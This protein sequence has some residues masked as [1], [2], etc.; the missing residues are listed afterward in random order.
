PNWRVFAF[1]RGAPG[2]ADFQNLDATEMEQGHPVGAW[3]VGEVI[4]DVQD[5]TLR[6][7]WKSRTATLYVGLVF[8]SGHDVGDR[9]PAS[10]PNVV[11]RAIAVKTFDVD[12]AKAPPPPGTI[13]IPHASGPI[14]IDGMATDPGWATAITSP[15]FQPAEGGCGEPVG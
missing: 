12:L 3:H 5:F 6:P 10:G 4:Q 15:E 11:D 14:A 7:D 1:V 8:Q 13:Y 2:S 9:M